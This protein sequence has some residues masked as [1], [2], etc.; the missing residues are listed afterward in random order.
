MIN[1]QIKLIDG[2]VLDYTGINPDHFEVS[3][4]VLLL[5]LND[6]GTSMRTIPLS[7]VLYVDAQEEGS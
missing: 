4:H 3:Q 7:S 6:E 1:L 2:D 5:T